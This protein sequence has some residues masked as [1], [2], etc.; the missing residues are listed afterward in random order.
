MAA[1][2]FDAEG[3]A[4]ITRM[5]RW[6]RQW[7]QNRN[8]F[9]TGGLDRSLAAV[10]GRWLLAKNVS[11]EVAP[12]YGVCR[13]TGPDTLPTVDAVN[14]VI[15]IDKPSTV[16]TRL[17]AVIGPQAIAAGQYGA[18]TLDPFVEVLFDSGTPNNGEG[19]GPKANTWTVTKNY[20]TA[21]SVLG[22]IAAGGALPDRIW[23][24]LSP[25]NAVIGKLAGSLSQGASATVNIWGGAAGGETVISSLTLMGQDWLMK[26]GATAIASGKKVQCT[27]INGIWYV[28]EAECA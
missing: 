16:F 22:K 9:A 18:V 1:Y 24:Q 2:T 21:V 23:G 25:I 11:G 28:T 15:A 27:W 12:A 13:I 3:A 7:P 4:E 19:W 14:N 5:V 26:S 17:Y 8:P 20:P 10:P 6:W